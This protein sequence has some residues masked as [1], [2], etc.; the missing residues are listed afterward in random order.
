MSEETENDPETE[1]D[2][3]VVYDTEEKFPRD[4]N[5][6]TTKANKGKRQT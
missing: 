1:N 4:Y 3:H 6:V 2:D 5:S